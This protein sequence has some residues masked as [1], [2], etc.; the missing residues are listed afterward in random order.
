VLEVIHAMYPEAPV[1]TSIFRPEALPP[2]YRTWDVRPSFLNRVPGA[3][4]CHQW[5]L[6]FYPYAFERMDLPGYDLVLSVTSAFAHGVNPRNDAVH[7]CYCLTPARF[8]WDYDTYMAREELGRGTRWLLPW[9]ISRLQRWDLRAASR[10]HSF[11]AI[12]GAVQARIRRFYQRDAEIIYPPT[13]VQRCRFSAERGDYFLI[14]S[15]LV[16]YKR[17]DLAVQ[18]FNELGLPLVIIGDG[19]DRPALEAMARPNVRF[20]GRLA[21]EEAGRY[22]T[23]CRAFVFPGEEDFGIAPLEAQAAGRPVIAYAG[24][25]ALETITDGVTGVFFRE[26]TPESLVGAVRRF[27]ETRFDHSAI[28]DSALRFDRTVFERRLA[29]FVRTTLGEFT[30]RQSS[31]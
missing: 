24:G 15:R 26:Q 29:E 18:A 11:V 13:D 8:L 4:R 22:L 20:L 28:R 16:P 7:I 10:V 14:I 25:G 21:D 12:S 23:R 3:T 31:D 17:I 27:S 5:L 9:L 6:P 30:V 1:Y 2:A 19:R